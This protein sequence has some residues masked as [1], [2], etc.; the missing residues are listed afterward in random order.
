MEKELNRE[1]AKTIESLT[2]AKLALRK[3]AP[4]SLRCQTAYVKY[5]DLK[6]K[7]NNLFQ[8]IEAIN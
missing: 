5:Q 4:L 3:T 8:Q 7:A 2:L 6:R 1:L